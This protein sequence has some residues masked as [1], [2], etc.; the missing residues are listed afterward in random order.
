MSDRLKEAREV[1]ANLV[2]ALEEE[3][4]GTVDAVTEARW[5]LEDTQPELYAVQFRSMRTAIHNVIIF[6]DRENAERFFTALALETSE[7]LEDKPEAREALD[8]VFNFCI[9]LAVDMFEIDF[10]NPPK[11]YKEYRLVYSNTGAR[12]YIPDSYCLG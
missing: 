4:L 9:A 6:D 11:E 12:A 7:K 10:R 8:S 2:E 3:G 5:F 1:I